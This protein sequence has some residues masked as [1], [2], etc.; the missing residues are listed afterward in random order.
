MAMLR[1]G[2]GLPL[3]YPDQHVVK[4]KRSLLKHKP[5]QFIKV[6]KTK[7]PQ[8]VKNINYLD[9]SSQCSK[10]IDFGQ[11]HEK[12]GRPGHKKVTRSKVKSSDKKKSGNVAIDIVGPKSSITQKKREV[13]CQTESRVGGKEVVLETEVVQLSDIEGSLEICI[14]LQISFQCG[15]FDFLVVAS[16]HSR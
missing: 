7:Q 3:Q 14:F 8:N 6:S 11:R 15:L 9:L 16:C 2:Y 10:V 12:K 4:V 5:A 1:S 13:H